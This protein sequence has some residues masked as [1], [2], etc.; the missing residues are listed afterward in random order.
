[1]V[2]PK[3][4]R[5]RR[6]ERGFTLVELMVVVVIIAILA[7]VVVPMFTSEAKKVRSKSE[8]NPMMAEL[9]TKQERYKSENNVYL[10][11]AECPTPASNVEKSLTTNCL[12]AL[13]PMTT[14]GVQAPEENVRCSY[15]VIVGTSADNPATMIPVGATYTVPPGCCATSWYMIHAKCDADGNGTFSHYMTASFDAT[16]QITNEGH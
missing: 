14:L 9:A 12:V 2:R 15:E 3:S 7:A 1:M 5:E 6:G 11:V 10:A 16:M 13:A 8:V 4:P